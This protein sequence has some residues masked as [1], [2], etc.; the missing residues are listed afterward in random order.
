MN[1]LIIAGM[2]ASGKST[3]SSRI[4]KHFGYPILEKDSI[5]EE[6]FDTIG[7]T[8]YAEKRQL[9]VAA[10]AVLLRCVD[11]L[12]KA[13]MSHIIVNNFREDASD[14]VRALLAKHN[15]NCVTLFFKGDADVFYERYAA[16][17][18]RGA[19]HVGHALQEH[20]PPLEGDP[21]TYVLTREEFADRFEKLGM[22]KFDIG[23]TRIE[24]DATYPD[25]IDIDALIAEIEAAFDRK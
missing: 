11:D 22:D 14:D 15:A 17:D 1:L 18:A 25:K 16:R 8:C 19:R 20:Y 7:F 2:P 3:V 12:L 13:G 6:L 4:S 23:G 21:K 24:I 9:D 5:K 10:T